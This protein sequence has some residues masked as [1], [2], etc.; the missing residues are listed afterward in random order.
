[1]GVQPVQLT[2]LNNIHYSPKRAGP[3]HERNMPGELRFIRDHQEDN[4]LII[5]S[6]LANLYS[7]YDKAKRSG[8]A[9]TQPNQVD[10][11]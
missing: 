7:Q 3:Y 6:N 2:L 9:A 5:P 8:P 4:I 1:M 10:D 11:P